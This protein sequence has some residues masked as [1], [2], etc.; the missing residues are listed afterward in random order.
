M[1]HLIMCTAMVCLAAFGLAPVAAEE[2][3]SELRQQAEERLQKRWQEDL[4]QGPALDLVFRLDQAFIIHALVLRVPW[5]G[6]AW[7]RVEIE[8]VPDDVLIQDVD[9][10]E[11]I[12]QRDESGAVVAVDGSLLLTWTPRTMLTRGGFLWQHRLQEDS[13]AYVQRQERISVSTSPQRNS[14]AYR[15]HAENAIDGE[16]KGLDVLLHRRDGTWISATGSSPT[17]NR[18]SHVV[19]SDGFTVDSPQRLSG[20]LDITLLA[21]GWVPS[22]GEPRP[23]SLA[24]EVDINSQGTISGTYQLSGSMGERSGAI[25]GTRR[26]E[27]LGSYRFMREQELNGRL[28]VKVEQV[29]PEHALALDQDNGAVELNDLHRA[30]AAHLAWSDYP[31]RLADAAAAVTVAAGTIAE[32]ALRPWLHSSLFAEPIAAEV[33]QADP[34]FGPHHGEDLLELSDGVNQLPAVNSDAPQRWQRLSAWQVIGPFVVDEFPTA[35]MPEII[36]PFTYPADALGTTGVEAT[37]L[38]WES[39][40]SIHRDP[41]PAVPDRVGRDWDYSERRHSGR[42]Q[43]SLTFASTSVDVAASGDYFLA[44]RGAQEAVQVWINRRLV[45]YTPPAQLRNPQQ[46]IILRLPLEAGRNEMLLRISNHLEATTAELWFCTAGSPESVNPT[47]ASLPPPQLQGWRGPNNT[48]RYPDA[49]PPLVWNDESGFNVAWRRSVPAGDGG[50]VAVG[51][52]V[53]ATANPDQ[54]LAVDLAS[55]ELLWQVEASG[56]SAEGNTASTT[57][58]AT[59]DRVWAWFG[60]GRALCVDHQGTLQWSVDTGLRAQGIHLATPLVVDD[61]LIIHGQDP[62]SEQV[63]VQALDA[64][65]GETRWQRHLSGEPVDYIAWTPRPADFRWFW[66]GMPGNGWGLAAMRLHHD[67]QHRDVIITHDGALIA[68]S[69][70]ALLSRRMPIIYG[71]RLPPL[72]DGNRAYFSTN[73]GHSAVELWLEADGRVGY[74]QAWQTRRRSFSGGY[75]PLLSSSSWPMPP[76]M[77]D[78]QLFTLRVHHIHRPRHAVRPYS[79]GDVYDPETGHWLAHRW[80]LADGGPNPS[81]PMIQAGEW[82]LAGNSGQGCRMSFARPKGQLN[83]A[84]PGRSL[85]VLMRNDIDPTYAAPVA[86]G[87]YLLIRGPEAITAYAVTDD[88]GR[89]NQWNRIAE[90][91]MAQIP[92]QPRGDSATPIAATPG[93]FHGQDR[94]PVVDIQPGICFGEWLVLGPLAPNTLEENPHI[95]GIDTLPQVGDSLAGSQWWSLSP[96]DHHIMS[97]RFAPEFHWATDRPAVDHRINLAALTDGRPQP[98]TLLM[99]TVL[100]IPETITAQLLSGLSAGEATAWLGGQQVDLDTPLR[101]EAGTHT[102]LLRLDIGRLPPFVRGL[103]AKPHLALM[104][105]QDDAVQ[106]WYDMIAE[107]KPILERI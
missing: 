101:L 95:A 83:V 102:L 77:I 75:V 51:E 15:L 107:R 46:P 20:T 31:R 104:P 88:E 44:L 63:V 98:G 9:T 37:E 66:D 70:G 1:R 90:E 64:A 23:V 61:L 45:E 28:T 60:T 71:N 106:A 42:P 18:A 74:R 30:L 10:S 40:A 56:I 17:W 26:Q 13:D 82:L 48:S 6:G 62:E 69:D 58:V 85:Q 2:S 68:A 38:S 99:T 103:E 93:N 97:T 92:Q 35:P 79:S 34:R 14:V 57:P 49:E 100:S 87:P 21:D 25:S 24:S 12:L 76:L 3:L 94:V 67:D 73:L 47:S 59:E 22:D 54:L 55:G 29:D 19:D 27:L 86:V 96:R 89:R 91:Q 11:L 36:P 53:F 84:M 5:R 8:S 78:D 33:L 72:I 52:R 43:R 50:L 4:A 65:S 105:N 39:M 80:D 7:Q 16:E 32:D 81:M 41:V